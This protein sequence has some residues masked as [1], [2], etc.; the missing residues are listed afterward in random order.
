MKDNNNQII[1]IK[2]EKT[3]VK[4]YNNDNIENKNFNYYHKNNLNIKM[5]ERQKRRMEKKR[6]LEEELYLSLKHKIYLF[7]IWLVFIIT[8]ISGFIVHYDTIENVTAS[9]ILWTF[10]SIICIL[11]ILYTYCYYKCIH[12]K[13]IKEQQK[14]LKYIPC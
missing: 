12:A 11:A 13:S 10:S 3:I 9:S 6:Q 2:E 14:Y 4:N 5:N 8:F 1:E 7:S